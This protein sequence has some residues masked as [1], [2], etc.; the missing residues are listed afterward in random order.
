MSKKL[1]QEYCTVC[2]KPLSRASRRKTLFCRV[3]VATLKKNSLKVNCFICEK[4][5]ERYP[6]EYNK[7]KTHLC[8]TKCAGKWQ[9]IYRIGQNSARG[10]TGQSKE[11]LAKKIKVRSQLNHAI[12]DGKVIR[13]PCKECGNPR[14][15]AHHHD[16]NKPYDV[17]WL[18]RQHHNHITWSK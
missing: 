12:R 5:F 15:E 6:S 2:N 16:Y 13:M 8:S 1:P 14:S 9:S 10:G 17:E 18:C 4:E 11:E 3:H 7:R